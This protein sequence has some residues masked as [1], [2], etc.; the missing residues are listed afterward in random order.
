MNTTRRALLGASAMTVLARHA[1]AQASYPTRPVRVLIP[2]TSGGASDTALRLTA[3]ALSQTLGQPFVVENR[4]GGNTI[5]AADLVAKSPP[6]GYTL[7]FCSSST[8]STNPVLYGERLPYDP[9]RDFAPVG[10]VMR[11]P[12]FVFVPADSPARNLEEFLAM[13]RARPGQLTFASI[14]NGTVGHL[15]SEMLT[16][17]AG[18]NMLHVVY[19]GYSNVAPDLA[20]GRLSMTVADLTTFG[21]LLKAGQLRV[22]AA[23]TRERSDFLPDVPGMSELGFREVDA[24]VWAALFAPA[25]T[26]PAVI[27][28]LNEA[29]QGYLR[30][31]AARN[32]FAGTSQVPTPAPPEELR[33]QVRA[34]AGVYGPL[35]RSLG[36]TVD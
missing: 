27:A 8:M 21:P 10:L 28:R 7:L 24:S 35:I 25:A 22:L 3:S 18:V 2:F 29:L 6:D 1:A 12:Y 26:P 30:T 17:A 19:R 14:G 13:A 34:D 16:R 33:Q 4:P 31:E 5:I 15:A 23:G 9:E 11:L 32:A 36:I 20:A